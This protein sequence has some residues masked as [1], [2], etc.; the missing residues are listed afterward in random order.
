MQNFNTYQQFQPQYR[1]M[2]MVYKAMPVTSEA[3]MNTYTVDFNGMPTYFHNQATNE[4]YVKQFDIKTGLTTT[5]K[6]IKFER[7]NKPVEENKTEIDRS[8]YSENFNALN[9]RLDSLEK[10]I[11]N[12]QVNSNDIKGVKN[13]K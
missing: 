4:I 2:Q 3:E 5:Q 11:K 1:Q 9:E 8:I 10:L 13:V 12:F 7:A 6:Y